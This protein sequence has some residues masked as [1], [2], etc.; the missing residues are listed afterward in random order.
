[1]RRR[2]FITAI[3]SSAA[4]WPLGVR[5][6]QPSAGKGPRVGILM[7][8]P[9]AHSEAVL[10]PFYQGL[11]E[12]GYVEGQNLAVELRNADWK[13]DRLPALAAELV[14]LKVD[15]IVAWST[16]SARA[17]KQVTNSIPIIA[18]VMA[19]PVGDELVA[20]LAR[21]GGNVTGTTFLGPEL[22]A[23]R[24]QLLR[25]VVPG[26]ARVAALWHPHAYG[27]RTMTNIVKDIE[28]AARTLGMQLQLV[29]ADGP[30]D[31][32]SAFAAMAK[33]RAD[34]FIVMPSPMLF[35]EHQHIVELAANN[36]LPGMY[37][38]REF[39]DAGGLMSYGA[40]LDDLFRRTAPYV[41]KI[42]KGAKPAELP[43]ERPTKFELV[44][45]MKNAR[46]LG[47]TINRD[48]QLVADELVE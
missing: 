12:L 19:D 40:N 32:A 26:L 36:R 47:L 6:Q 45:N 22:I 10:K 11:H 3:A 16:S 27:E 24:L 13:P 25:D 31:I 7:P 4:T 43:V 30:G 23:K 15:I 35:G 28:E 34:A 46:A 18:A 9:A 37:Q 48:I 29:P 39:V 21:P 41:D 2:D 1:M 5:A 17:A 44:I 33:E 20:S 42:L 8:G 38:A 14:G